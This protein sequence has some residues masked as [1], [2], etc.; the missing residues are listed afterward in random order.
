MSARNQTNWR[1]KPATFG[2]FPWYRATFLREEGRLAALAGDTAGAVRAYRH[3]LAIRP[4]P[5]PEAAIEDAAVR[6]RLAELVH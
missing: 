1:T 6:A 3:Y 4:V 2:T 5:E